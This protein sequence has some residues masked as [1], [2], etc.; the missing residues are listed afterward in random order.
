MSRAALALYE[1]TTEP[2]Y[3]EAAQ[4]WQRTLEHHHAAPTGNYYLTADDAEG[5]I[6]RP[7]A[8]TDDATPNHNAVIAQNL[9]RLASSPETTRIANEPTGSRRARAPRGSQSLRPCRDLQRDRLP[10]P[11]DRNRHQRGGS[12]RRRISG[13]CARIAEPQPDHPVRAESARR[14]AAVASCSRQS[15]AAAAAAFVCIGDSAPCRSR[16]G[17]LIQAAADFIANPRICDAY[18]PSLA[19]PTAAVY[20]STCVMRSR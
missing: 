11:D 6:V 17:A 20:C 8:T 13:S 4:V 12:R 10:Y 15:R 9:I 3:L 19:A 16:P 2:A 1:A 14:L 18:A 7:S 5:L